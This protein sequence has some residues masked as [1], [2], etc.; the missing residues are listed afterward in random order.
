ML[1]V[2]GDASLT[3]GVGTLPNQSSTTQIQENIGSDMAM[4]MD[5]LKPYRRIR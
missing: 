1:K 5:L 3:M 4:A 2:R